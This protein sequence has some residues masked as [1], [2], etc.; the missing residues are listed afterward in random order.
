MEYERRFCATV[1]GKRRSVTVFLP[2]GRANDAEYAEM[3]VMNDQPL[4]REF[5][6]GA[7]YDDY[8]APLVN[9]RLVKP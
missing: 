2:H 7:V 8:D 5:Y 6:A 9:M 4:Y 3:I 1:N